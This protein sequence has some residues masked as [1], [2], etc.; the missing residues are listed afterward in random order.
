L[1]ADRHNS[2]GA[3]C[4]LVGLEEFEKRSPRRIRAKVRGKQ[5][6]KVLELLERAAVTKNF[7][8]GIDS[9]ERDAFDVPAAIKVAWGLRGGD[10]APVEVCRATASSLKVLE[11]TK[12][13]PT[14]PAPARRTPEAGCDVIP[15]GP[16]EAH[17]EQS[18]RVECR[19]H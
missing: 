12:E 18:A 6:A 10:E 13:S 7:E 14:K 5:L 9:F 1:K 17:G 4:G 15:F 16:M 11:R 19:N 2:F 3:A 8:D